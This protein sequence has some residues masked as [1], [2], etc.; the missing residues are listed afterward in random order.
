M[1][2]KEKNM[3][4]F[5]FIVGILNL[6]VLLLSSSLIYYPEL[7]LENI[8]PV[9]WKIAILMWALVVSILWLLLIYNNK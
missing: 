5:K 7:Y 6:I 3:K 8:I 2:R 9:L 4:S 1:K